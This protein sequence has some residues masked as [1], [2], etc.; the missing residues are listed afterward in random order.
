MNFEKIMELIF[1]QLSQLYPQLKTYFRFCAQ[2]GR[3]VLMGF[4]QQ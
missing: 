1:H 4:L 2:G 3:S